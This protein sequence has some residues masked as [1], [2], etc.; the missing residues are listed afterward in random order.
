MTAPGT[1]VPLSNNEEQ[2]GHPAVTGLYYKRKWVRT[3]GPVAEVNYE[4]E[5]YRV[6]GPSETGGAKSKPKSDLQDYL[7]QQ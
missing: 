3:R 7:T 6:S 2:Y 5:P 1:P 4:L